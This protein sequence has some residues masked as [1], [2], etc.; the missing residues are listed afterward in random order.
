MP[1]SL[2]MRVTPVQREVLLRAYEHPEGIILAEWRTIGCLVRR[3]LAYS[4]AGSSGQTGSSGFSQATFI[5]DEGRVWVATH[6]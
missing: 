1:A 2:S 3:G 6:A 5:T 4:L